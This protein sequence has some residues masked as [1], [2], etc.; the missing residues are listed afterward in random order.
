MICFFRSRTLQR[1]RG[2]QLGIRRLVHSFLD[3][4]LL[5]VAALVEGRAGITYG[6]S[7]VVVLLSRVKECLQCMRAKCALSDLLAVSENRDP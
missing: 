7:A 2:Q 4:R 6:F 5:L 3:I 1:W